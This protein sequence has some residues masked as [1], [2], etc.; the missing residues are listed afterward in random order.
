M[1]NLHG[2]TIIYRPIQQVFDFMST[3]ENDFQ[4][5]DGTLATTRLSGEVREMGA[6][7]RSIGHL[8]G[9]R[10]LTTFEITEYQPG[11]RYRVRSLSGPLHSQT[12]YIFAVAD[13]QTRIDIS[14]RANVVDFFQIGERLLEKRMKK[15]LK[16]NL[17]MLKDF[18]EEKPIPCLN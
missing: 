15:Q 17:A 1:I 3:P 2:S 7:F 6:L 9:H 13:G 16:E 14:T 8:M 11:R 4:W 12:T 18:L 5:Q 10:L